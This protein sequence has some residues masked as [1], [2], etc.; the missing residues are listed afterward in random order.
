MTYKLA[1][2]ASVEAISLPSNTLLT[3]AAESLVSTAFLVAARS[4][5]LATIC[6]V[7]VNLAMD[8][9]DLMRNLTVKIMSMQ[10]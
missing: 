6:M 9:T 1:G 2:F 7:L 8:V 5:E 10:M 3:D 4:L